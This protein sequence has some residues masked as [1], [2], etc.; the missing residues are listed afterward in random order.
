MKGTQY[1][2]R[3]GI[4][5]SWP[6]GFGSQNLRSILLSLVTAQTE[7]LMNP[8]VR[9]KQ[10]PRSR[11]S[12]DDPASARYRSHAAH[13]MPRRPRPAAAGCAWENREGHPRVTQMRGAAGF[14]GGWS[15]SK[16][17]I[18]GGVPRRPFPMVRRA[19]L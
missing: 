13:P 17:G 9:G 18:L 15:F 3:T 4:L 10:S 19:C 2:N 8:T 11:L 7:Y 6:V 1:I 16:N 14:R 12:R 5:T